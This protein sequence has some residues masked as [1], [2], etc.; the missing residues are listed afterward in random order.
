MDIINSNLSI[1]NKG[2]IVIKLFIKLF[3]GQISFGL[4]NFNFNTLF[5]FLYNLNIKIIGVLM[6]NLLN[7]FS[8]NSI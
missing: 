3:Y 7:K 2:S 5:F 4:L 1:E 8:N 6:T